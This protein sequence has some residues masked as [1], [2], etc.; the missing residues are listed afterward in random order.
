[1]GG[2]R[3][4]ASPPREKRRL[5]PAPA[6]ARGKAGT[7]GREAGFLR[8]LEGA[9][10]LRAGTLLRAGALRRAG[11]RA[12]RRVG[13]LFR[14][15]F[16]RATFLRVVFRPL[17]R[18]GAFRRAA[19]RRAVFLRAGF[20]VLRRAG[21]FRRAALRALRRAGPLR[22]A[23][24][25]VLRRAGALRRAPFL[26]GLRRRAAR[27]RRALRNFPRRELFVLLCERG[28]RRAPVR[29]LG[30]FR[31]LALRRFFLFTAMFLPYFR[32]ALDVVD[33]VL[34][35]AL[36][37]QDIADVAAVQLVPRISEEER[38]E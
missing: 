37:Q 6:G 15:T 20:R 8:F 30:A 38:R 5:D 29:R 22:R 33:L 28:R 12:L 36:R 32:P 27:V 25:R 34:S 18:A 31:P 19:F 9:A 7:E 17:R 16:R 10:L 13:A 21:A 23:V 1:M 14:A 11:L 4:A 2:F 26:A 3:R 24:L 35:E